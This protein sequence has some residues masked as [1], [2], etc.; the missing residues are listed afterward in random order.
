MLRR[1]EIEGLWCFPTH[2]S[3]DDEIRLLR[4]SLYVYAYEHGLET[5]IHGE[6]ATWLGEHRVRPVLVAGST[7]TTWCAMPAGKSISVG[8]RPR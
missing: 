4:L 6:L 1:R 2:H 8:V 5:G 3:I 7:H